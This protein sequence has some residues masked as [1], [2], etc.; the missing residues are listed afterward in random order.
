M[1]IAR[2]MNPSCNVEPE[3]TKAFR[4]MPIQIWTPSGLQS[5]RAYCI[6]V[7]ANCRASSKSIPRE[8]LEPPESP[9]S[10]DSPESPES[11]GLPVGP[12]PVQKGPSGASR[13]AS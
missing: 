8:S 12:I 1:Q 4:G 3:R 13:G 10:P 5:G 9:E 2:K 6:G 11:P 7:S